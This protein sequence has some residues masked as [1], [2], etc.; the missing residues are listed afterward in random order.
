MLGPGEEP[1]PKFINKVVH[2]DNLLY[3]VSIRTTILRR[4]YMLN[5]DYTTKLLFTGIQISHV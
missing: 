4:F 5:R 1:G 3:H 2:R